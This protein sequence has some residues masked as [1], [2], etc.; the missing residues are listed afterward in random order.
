MN[1]KQ[2]HQQDATQRIV[3]L[4]R[5]RDTLKIQL[6]SLDTMIAEIPPEGDS[7]GE[8]ERSAEHCRQSR[9]V[10]AFRLTG[11]SV[12]S[13][14]N[15]KLIC[16]YDTSYN[17]LCYETFYIEIC[18]LE[19]ETC[20]VE[21]HSIPCFIPVLELEKKLLKVDPKQ[22]FLKLSDYLFAYVSRKEELRLLQEKESKKISVTVTYSKPVDFVEIKIGNH[23]DIIKLEWQ[24]TYTDL[25]H[26][27]PT[28]V[29]LDVIAIDDSEDHSIKPKETLV[30][31]WTQSLKNKPLCGAVDDIIHDYCELVK[32]D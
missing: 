6:K 30:Q 26:T 27:R 31:E 4:R 7:S 1:R 22:F 20:K 12:H 2:S 5:E 10:D 24:L 29:R 14:T 21:R 15:D 8:V 3:Q 19:K 32:P 17:G 28:K 23:K 9:I 11:F 18:D 25:L 16:S 13:V